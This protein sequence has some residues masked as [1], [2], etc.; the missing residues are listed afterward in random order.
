MARAAVPARAVARGGPADAALL[1]ADQGV[2][3]DPGCLGAPVQLGG[4]EIF[5]HEASRPDARADD[6]GVAGGGACSRPGVLPL[7]T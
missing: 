6:A 4:Y 7:R 2:R 1:P 5:A 3:P